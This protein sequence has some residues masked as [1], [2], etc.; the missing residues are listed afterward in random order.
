MAAKL[1]LILMPVIICLCMFRMLSSF[2]RS[3]LMAALVSLF[4]VLYPIAP[5]QSYFLT[6]AHPTAG[7]TIFLMVACF[8]LTLLTKQRNW[9][10]WKSLLCFLACCAGFYVLSRTSP[11]FSLV[12]LVL[13]PMAATILWTDRKR[14]SKLHA[15]YL[16]AP[17]ALLALI[18]LKSGNY[19][20][21]SLVGWTEISVTRTM[22]NLF[23]AM[24]AVFQTP[25]RFHPN[26][27][28]VSTISLIIFVGAIVGLSSVLIR[29]RSNGIFSAH[30]SLWP[31]LLFLLTTAALV[32]GP[33]SVTTN[34]LLRYTL[35][36]FQIGSLFI[37]I[38]IVIVFDNAP[39]RQHAMRLAGVGALSIMVATVFYHTYAS[40]QKRLSP[41][42]ATHTKITQLLDQKQWSS[43]DQIL[44]LL[45]PGEIEMTAGYNHW[46]TWYLRVITGAPKLVGLV[47][48]HGY[49]ND[50]LS[51]GLFVDRYKD[52]D[53]IYWSVQNGVSQRAHMLGLLRDR[54][55]YTYADNEGILTLMPLVLETGRETI[56]LEPG[57]TL[58]E[59]LSTKVSADKCGPIASYENVISNPISSG[60]KLT[61][62]IRTPRTID[63]DV[64]SI[65]DVRPT[66]I[67]ATGKTAEFVAIEDDPSGNTSVYIELMNASD[68]QPQPYSDTYPQM[69]FVAPGLAIYLQ[70]DTYIFQE[71]GKNSALYIS[72]VHP[73]K[74]TTIDIVDCAAGPSMN[75][76][77]VDGIYRGVLSQDVIYG[78][79]RVGAGFLDRYWTGEITQFQLRTSKP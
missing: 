71:I 3:P 55:T 9:P 47:G 40:T 78:R 70:N 14:L 30:P 69:P 19:H 41:L 34:F 79:W 62:P 21:S 67:I 74:P 16:V 75:A 46:S 22:Q 32:F 57:Q 1:V 42:L 20:Y 11:T 52:H 64:T 17:A 73:D 38:L 28:I 33:G 10:V 7:I 31:F 50:L 25:Y 51:N 6:G 54:S 15:I 26:T 61:V 44:M 48:G 29:R 63:A 39:S 65:M 68:S 24:E 35:A 58:Q 66:P 72:P 23:S 12:P 59:K 56:L 36:P 60:P 77:Y 43:N 53:P 37:G 18:F 13:L 5:D 76:L 4:I 45:P 2:T 27:L 49:S 8:Y